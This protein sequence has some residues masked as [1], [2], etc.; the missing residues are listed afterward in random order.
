[1]AMS[2]Y[3]QAYIAF[4]RE[5]IAIADSLISNSILLNP[6]YPEAYYLR[7]MVR[8]A[9]KNPFAALVD[10]ETVIQLDPGNIEARF[11]KATL[12]YEL[13]NY[14]QAVADAN[15]ILKE[16]RSYETTTVYYKAGP[17]GTISGASTINRME[18]DLH[19]LIGLSYQGMEQ[20][21][22]AISSFNE[23]ISL[24]TDEPQYYNNLGQ[25][26]LLSGD[27]VN[28]ITSFKKGIAIDPENGTLIYNLS[29]LIEISDDQYASMFAEVSNPAPFVSRAYEKFQSEDYDGA[30]IDYSLALDI[31]DKNAIVFTDRGR[32]YARLKRH[33]EAIS[34][35]QRALRL[36]ESL[37][38]NYYLQADSYQA[39]R[40]Y[41]RANDLYEY[42][43]IHDNTTP[44]V[45]YNFAICL[46]LSGN[47]SEACE[48]LDHALRLGL[49]LAEDLRPT[50]CQNP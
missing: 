16:E 20:Y 5:N 2:N 10:Y 46:H 7:A 47:D 3:N 9:Q 40:Q 28:A 43:L 23:A 15:I 8:E 4:D 35:Y 48:Q 34:D 14:E 32:T 19:H 17:D 1:M 41:Q 6:G 50:F 12:H 18:A 31:N 37:I 27:S 22:Q 33:K 26:Y 13:G 38:Q 24:N 39:I 21:T 45:Y 11:K 29:R 49:D 25:T 30:L 42:Y 36:D 44:A